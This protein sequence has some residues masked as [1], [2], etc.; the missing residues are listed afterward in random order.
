MLPLE[1]LSYDVEVV[2]PL[3]EVVVHQRF[4]N[5]S[6]VFVDATYLF[7]MD[8]E[9]V[10]DGMTLRIGAASSPAGPAIASA[11]PSTPSSRT[12]TIRSA[13]RTI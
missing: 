10:I 8:P 13:A 11:P 2:G 12:S 6:S 4:V 3:A 5:A 1:G 9:A 7:T